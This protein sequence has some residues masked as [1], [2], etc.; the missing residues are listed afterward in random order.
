MGVIE[1]QIQLIH[2]VLKRTE[3]LPESIKIAAYDQINRDLRMT[4]IH[5]EKNN[6]KPTSKQ[7]EY[8]KT[9][10]IIKPERYTKNELSVE[11]DK[12]LNK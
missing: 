4:E 11:I 10:G 9:L 1:H 3:G 12:K 8:A 2:E 6:Q 7:I 5:K